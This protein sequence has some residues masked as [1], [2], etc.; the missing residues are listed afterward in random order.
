MGEVTRPIISIALVLCAVFIP[1]AF[2]SG[3]TG[4][5]YRQFGVTIAASTL[6]FDLQFADACRRPCGAAAEAEGRAARTGFSAASI[7]SLGGFLRLQSRFEALSDALRSRRATS[8]G[9]PP[10]RAGGFVGL[11]VGT[12][13]IFQV[14][15]GASFP[16]RTSSI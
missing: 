10:G 15:P 8:D 1:V 3:L 14:V 13:G 11:L 4:E 5:F 2:V 16:R 7:A 9:S 12:W 6:Y